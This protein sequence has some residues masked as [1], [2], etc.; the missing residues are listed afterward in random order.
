[1]GSISMNYSTLKFNL[2][3]ITVA[4][5]VEANPQKHYP[6]LK[7]ALRCLYIAPLSY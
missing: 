4:S 3:K 6:S 5:H 2:F 1:M 7:A